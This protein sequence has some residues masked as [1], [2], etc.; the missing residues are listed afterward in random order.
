MHDQITVTGLRID[1]S[2]TRANNITNQYNVR[3]R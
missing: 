2:A 3:C 1:A